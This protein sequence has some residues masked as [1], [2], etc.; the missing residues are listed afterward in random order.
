MVLLSVTERQGHAE[1]HQHGNE[2]SDGAG[3]GHQHSRAA[4]ETAAATLV[5]SRKV[6]GRQVG[7]AHADPRRRSSW[8]LACM[9]ASRSVEQGAWS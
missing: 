2:H 8:H 9:I 4:R 5:T 7:G 3:G 1:F 6:T